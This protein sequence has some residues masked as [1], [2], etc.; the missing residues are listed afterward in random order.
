MNL[1]ERINLSIK[2]PPYF[3]QHLQLKQTMRKNKMATERWTLTFRLVCDPGRK[4]ERKRNAS[5]VCTSAATLTWERDTEGENTKPY[6]TTKGTAGKKQ[7]VTTREGE[8]VGNEEERRK[9][10]QQ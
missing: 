5:D 10:T 7:R 2:R 8:R 9:S 3:P 6:A 1:W 4:K